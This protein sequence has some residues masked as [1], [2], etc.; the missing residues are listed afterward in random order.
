MQGQQSG[1]GQ[2]VQFAVKLMTV[3]YAEKTES[4]EATEEFRLEMIT[5]LE[6]WRAQRNSRIFSR[7]LARCVSLLCRTELQNS[8]SSEQVFDDIS[9]SGKRRPNCL[10]PLMNHL[11]SSNARWSIEYLGCGDRTPLGR[12]GN[13]GHFCLWRL[14]FIWACCTC[15]PVNCFSTCR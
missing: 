6:I 7:S 13:V 14:S 4:K 1:G 15:L 2:A 5:G 8:M 10:A 3:S 11:V 12:H 9:T